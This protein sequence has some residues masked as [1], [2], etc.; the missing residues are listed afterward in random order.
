MYLLLIGTLLLPLVSSCPL[1]CSCIE[2]RFLAIC[3]A[4][5]FGSVPV[6]LPSDITELS[7]SKNR[8]KLL[9][10][11]SIPANLGLIKLDLSENQIF[12]ISTLAFGA[13]NS[14]LQQ[15]LTTLTL[16]SNQITLVPTE[17]LQNLRFLQDLS[18]G[19]NSIKWM[20]AESFTGLTRLNNLDL[21]SNGLDQLAA[22]AFKGLDNLQSLNLSEN[23]LKILSP[24]MLRHLTSLSTLDL[25][26]NSIRMISPG[27]LSH[28]TRLDELF[29]TANRISALDPGIFTTISHNLK[30]LDLTRNEVT[31]LKHGVFRGCNQLI[32]LKLG[33]NMMS[34]ISEENE[35]P[36][37]GL[38]KLRVL[39][40]D[41]N[42][43]ISLPATSKAWNDL[44]NLQ[45]LYLSGNLLQILP[46]FE[47]ITM[48][49]GLQKLDISANL[50]S[51]LKA[52]SFRCFPNLE[53][54]D[55]SNNVISEVGT[56]TFG[57]NKILKVVNMVRNR[58]KTPNITWFTRPSTAEVPAT[59][60]VFHLATNPWTCDCRA[61]AFAAS[62]L[63]LKENVKIN[64]NEMTCHEP[65]P[66]RGRN[67]TW[68]ATE[69]KMDCKE[70]YN[71]TFLTI[72]LFV[73]IVFFCGAALLR[74]YA[75]KTKE[76]F[77]KPISK[78]L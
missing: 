69:A 71:F 64:M 32:T 57:R 39:R 76:G 63:D 18:L 16:H 34:Y 1:G 47:P 74:Y 51:T 37:Q 38:Y 73:V 24:G 54:L 67:F 6:G 23:S 25:S 42:R 53:N 52:G 33:H 68:L 46:E 66:L 8:I 43:L 49:P 14:A 17:A 21:S 65:S 58:L 31:S 28:F 44:K 41:S 7:L 5:D 72:L 48:L 78:Y 13:R 11:N 56:G 77:Q 15:A 27:S 55:V 75:C 50:L 29:L 35:Y 22:D 45:E 4:A 12:D 2:K 26:R 62:V 61:V 70:K 59:S 10:D 30:L 19:G 40:L 20:R 9:S 60:Y 36:F 3:D